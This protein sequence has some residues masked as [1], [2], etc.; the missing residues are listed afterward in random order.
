MIEIVVEKVDIKLLNEQRLA[1]TKLLWD[2]S[3]YNDHILWGLVEMLDTI[4]DK[5]M[6]EIKQVVK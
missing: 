2:E 5:H 4:C 1:L 6:D 3:K